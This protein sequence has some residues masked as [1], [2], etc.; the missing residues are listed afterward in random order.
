MLG[1]GVTVVSGGHDVILYGV[2]HFGGHRPIAVQIGPEPYAPR[3]EF[4]EPKIVPSV[5]NVHSCF[6]LVVGLCHYYIATQLV[7]KW[8]W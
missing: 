5:E 3:P 6:P 1:L 8:H 7:V 4:E 2:P